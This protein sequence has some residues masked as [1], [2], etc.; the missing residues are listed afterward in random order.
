[1]TT[2]VFLTSHAL[3]EEDV[4]DRTVI[5]LDVLRASS[6]IVTALNNGAKA[7]I[8]V[9][10]MAEAGKMASNLDHTT[11]LL[12]GERGGVKIEGYHLG[13]S[14]AEYSRKAVKERTII[15]NTTNGTGAITRAKAARHIL[16]GSLLNAET[17]VAMTRQLGLD[18]VIVCAGWRNRVSLED[19]LCAGLILDRLWNGDR[20]AVT[21]DTGRIAH[22]LYLHDRDRLAEAVSTCTHAQKLIGLGF[23]EDVAYCSRVDV[24]PVLPVFEDGR[25]VLHEAS[26]RKVP[27]G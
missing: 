13:N 10:D 14:P 15:M 25:L 24:L 12:G 7:I 16:I 23:A 21:S 2:E 11:F 1:M 6:T 5:V 3:T 9:S 20:P 26:K 8:P 17:V 19:T 4:K 18:V 22:I 27:A